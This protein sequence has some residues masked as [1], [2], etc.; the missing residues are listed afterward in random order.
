MG[1]FDGCFITMLGNNLAILTNLHGDK[2]SWGRSYLEAN[3]Q[4]GKLGELGDKS[5]RGKTY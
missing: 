2:P 1:I 5:N 4:E 3:P